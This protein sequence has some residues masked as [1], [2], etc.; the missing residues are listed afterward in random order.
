MAAVYKAY[1]PNVERH[2]ALKVLPRQYADDPNFV[3]RF[4]R[5]AKVIA[6]LEHPGILPVHDYGEADGYTYMVMRLVEGGS[7]AGLLR[8]DPLPLS[9]VCRV[10]AQIAAALDYA[11]SKGVVHRDV[12]PGNV[13]LD[14][15]GNCL[16][17]DF[18]IARVLEATGRYTITGAFIGTPAYASPEQALGRDL[19]W[20]SDIY[21]LGV[22]LYEM[23][24]G[25][26][27]F[28]ADT[29]MA[30]IMKHI[31]DPLPMPRSVN[32]DVPEAVQRVVLKALAKAPEDR[33]QSAADM[34]RA[35]SAAAKEGNASDLAGAPAGA[36]RMR[37]HWAWLALLLAAG[38]LVVGTVRGEFA[39]ISSLWHTQATGTFLPSAAPKLDTGLPVVAGTSI[40]NTPITAPTEPTPSTLPPAATPASTFPPEIPTSAAMTGVNWT[41]AQSFP[42]PGSG[43]TG[44]VRVEG[45]L[46]VMV[47]CSDHVYRLDL[48]GNLVGELKLPKAG[49]GPHDIGLAWDGSSLWGTW[50]SEVIQFDPNTGESISDFDTDLDGCSITWDGSALWIVDR[51]GNLSAYEQNGQRLRR[52]A[53]P[54]SG[55]V[56]GIAWADRGLWMLDEFGGLNR[57]DGDFAKVDSFSL[58]A[59]CGVSAYHY[60][61]SYG[62]YWDGE[63]LWVADASQSRIY[64]C[65][66]G[67]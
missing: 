11:H 4:K 2:V 22:I 16:L 50:W 27:P 15:Q 47:P 18:G 6:G 54:V 31:H 59:T 42:A 48:R 14:A 61:T 29:P 66:P 53:I 52:L 30:V 35:L 46:L 21:S 13:L 23:V 60:Q 17:T 36:R 10:V 49:C 37:F 39:S 62:M 5:E 58:A 51:A 20:R 3:R 67:R 63:S 8:G 7:L 25:R 28:Q 9:E 1:Q 40:P 45:E 55:V 41:Q 38:L 34:A 57:F 26:P 43:P 56:S 64:Q 24:T 65:V 44:I 32:P 33:Y 12:K 19:D